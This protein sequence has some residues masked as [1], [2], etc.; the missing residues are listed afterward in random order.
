[1]KPCRSLSFVPSL[2]AGAALAA[3]LFNVAPAAAQGQHNMGMPGPNAGGP[4]APP[5]AQPTAAPRAHARKARKAPLSGSTTAQL[6]AQELARIQAGAPASA[7]APA[8]PPPADWYS[9][10]G[11]RPAGR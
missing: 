11:A 10:Q 2:V 6:N 9:P 1:M 3:L 5:S 7:P 8:G 4:V